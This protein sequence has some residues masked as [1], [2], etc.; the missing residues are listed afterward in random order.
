MRKQF[1]FKDITLLPELC[2]VD[3]RSM[4]DTSVKF[5]NYI[6]K[7]PVVPANM[8]SI[9]DEELA[10]KLAEQGY[11]YILHRFNV[12]I[13]D[14]V[15]TMNNERL[16]T[17]ISIGVNEDSYI[18]LGDIMALKL[19]VDYITIDIAHGHS[20][21]LKKM[22]SFI[23]QH[24]PDTFV[25]GGNVSTPEAVKDLEEWGCDAVK[26]GIAG[27][28]VCT[29]DHM[30]GFGNRGWQASMIEECSKVA[31]K[32]IISDGS[33]KLN[34]DIIKS[35][36]MGAT[37]VMVGGMLSGYQES[38]GVIIYENAIRYKEFWG[39][40]SSRQSGKNNRIEGIRKLVPYTGDSIFNKLKEI[41]E[42]IQ[43]GISY[44]GGNPKNLSVFNNVKYRIIK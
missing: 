3:S 14:F 41:K 18:L 25:I 38:P 15:T 39:S 44:A 9:I 13:I 43:S 2:Y 12:D 1:D 40:A 31:K 11:F 33:I 34:S 37:M 10:I 30:T 17:S 36:V 35:L 24:M 4:C 26:C 27:G 29:T 7:L 8:E 16:V 28:S 5:G 42:C 20:L 23:K 19:H 22:V 21:K 6:F 32:P